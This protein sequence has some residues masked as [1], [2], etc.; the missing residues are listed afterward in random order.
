MGSV[1]SGLIIRAKKRH[2]SIAPQSNFDRDFGTKSTGEPAFVDRSR[3]G[4]GREENVFVPTFMERPRRKT[5]K[6][7]NRIGRS[8]V[9]LTS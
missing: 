7:L 6:C 9:K 8:K 1:K 4:A 3:Q 2:R 5:A